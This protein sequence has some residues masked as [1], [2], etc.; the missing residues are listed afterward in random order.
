MSLEAPEQND[1]PD[2]DVKLGD[3]MGEDNFAD[4]QRAIH[5]PATVTA[6]CEDYR[7]GLGSTAPTTRPTGPRA[8]AC[9]APRWC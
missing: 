5:D 6:M 1:T 3:R 2:K 9:A 7:A 8:A 4:Y